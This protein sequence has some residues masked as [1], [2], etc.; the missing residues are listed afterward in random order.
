[1]IIAMIINKFR[2]STRTTVQASKRASVRQPT[3]CR[4][5]KTGR[6]RKTKKLISMSEGST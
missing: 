2:L 5:R 6:K 3:I 4:L 1:M